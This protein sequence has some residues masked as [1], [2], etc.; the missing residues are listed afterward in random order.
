MLFGESR[1]IESTTAARTNMRELHF[2]SK[3]IQLFASNPEL[4]GALG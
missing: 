3:L 2:K 1:E 4:D